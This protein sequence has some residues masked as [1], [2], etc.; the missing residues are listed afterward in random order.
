[1]G[2]A[3]LGAQAAGAVLA[4]LGPLGTG[5][6]CLVQGIARGLDVSGYVRSPT[7]TL[8]HEYRGALPLYHVDLYRVDSSDLGGLGLEEILDG[9]GVTVIEW[10]ERAGAYLPQ[11]YLT[12]QLEFGPAESDRVLRLSHR[13]DRYRTIVEAASAC[14][15]SP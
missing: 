3:L 14:A 4:L 7:F 1:M 15:S 8:I 9:P 11:E 13:G 2:R 5:K 12:V 10:A 6:T